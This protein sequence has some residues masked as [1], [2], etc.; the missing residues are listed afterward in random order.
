MA[1]QFDR[2]VAIHRLVADS[3][4]IPQPEIIATDITLQSWPWRYLILAS[5][6]GVEWADLR[7]Y[8][9][10]EEL[11]SAY[12]QLGE[13]VGQM[14]Q[15]AF[16]AFGEIDSRGQVAQREPDFVSAIRMRALQ[17]IH[18]SQHCQLALEAIEQH[19]DYFRSVKGSRL[20][21]EDL[22]GHNILFCQESGVWRLAAVLDFDKAWAGH[23]EIDLS[24]LEL[25][26]GM[27]A[28]DFWA[29]YLALQIRDDDYV[30]RR[31]IYQLLWCLEYA[32]P[33]PQHLSD[34]R[35]VCQELGLSVIPEF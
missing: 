30:R 33:T 19:S 17:L 22:H 13:A 16:P 18:N 35:Q 3:T 11:S 12:R 2:T 5:V 6:P 31:P 7:H 25:W 23:A 14:H 20:S 8:L 28:P 15:I 24:R 9:S 1:S 10:A 26:R 34:T 21:H 4:T 32:S 29:A 27:T